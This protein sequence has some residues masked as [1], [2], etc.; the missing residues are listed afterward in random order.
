LGF[1]A[2]KVE[3]EPNLQFLGGA[4]NVNYRRNGRVILRM[5]Q[6]FYS[7][8][9]LLV[10]SP[11]FAEVCDKVRPTWKPSSGS[12]NQ[13]EELYYFFTS[14]LG[15]GLLFL[16]AA[17]YFVKRRWLSVLCGTL[18][19][20]T[21]ALIAANWF[22]LGDD[23]I[24]A[25][26]Q[27]GCRASPLVTIGVLALLSIWFFKY[28]RPRVTQ[29]LNTLN[30]GDDLDDV[31][32]L[33]AIEEIF[34]LVIKDGEAEKLVTMGDLYELVS[35][36]LNS[37]TDFDPVWSLL[38]QIAREHSGSRDPIDME[39]TFFPKFAEERIETTNVAGESI[40]RT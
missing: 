1:H 6:F 33:M 25:A 9:A 37:K 23:I 32:M 11:A 39:T 31:E 28:G 35:E 40:D 13:F 38:C 20:L 16:I 29:R 3:N 36:K 30:L 4:A 18:I 10:A 21:A 24:Y 27:E 2:A 7:I 34:G 8:I 26:H 19:V 12:I 15:I 14:P 17:T 22:W 5:K